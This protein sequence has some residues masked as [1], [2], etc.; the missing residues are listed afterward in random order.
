[1]DDTIRSTEPD[2]SFFAWLADDHE[3]L[4]LGLANEQAGAS[5]AEI[6]SAFQTRI[7]LDAPVS[8]EIAVLIS[9]EESDDGLIYK[10]EVPQPLLEDLK[11]VRLPNGT[12]RLTVSAKGYATEYRRIRV[13]DPADVPIDFHLER[14]PLLQGS[15]VDWEG[16]PL[17]GVLIE[18]AGGEELARSD[19]AGH[20]AF[21]VTGEIP[22]AIEFRLPGYGLRR[23]ELQQPEDFAV[24]VIRMYPAATMLVHFDPSNLFED[25]IA[26]LSVTLYRLTDDRLRR[27]AHSSIDAG[28]PVEFINLDPGDYRVHLQGDG[29]LQQLVH[30]ASVTSS[31]VEEVTLQPSA[32]T[33]DGRLRRDESPV[34]DAGVILKGLRPWQA[35]LTSDDEGRFGGEIWQSG[36]FAILVSGKH[37]DTPFGTMKTFTGDPVRLDIEIPSSS[38]YGSVVDASSGRP[39]RDAKIHIESVGDNVRFA[40]ST[41]TDAKGDYRFTAVRNGK[42]SLRVTAPDYLTAELFFEL[43]RDQEGYRADVRLE[44]GIEQ[45]VQILDVS[46]HPAAHATIM[47]GVSAGGLKPGKIITADSAGRATIRSREAIPAT[48]YVFS[49]DGSFLVWPFM[50]S[51]ET[52]GQVLVLPAASGSV[53]IRAVDEESTPVAR[54]SFLVRH[55]GHLLLP[56]VLQVMRAVQ[57]RRFETDSDG[58]LTFRNLPA[59]VYEFWPY[60]GNDS[61]TLLM[62]TPVPG[63]PS[64]TVGVS[65]ASAHHVLVRLNR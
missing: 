65:N 13:A 44:R 37:L 63:M 26:A 59:G 17:A 33:L 23:L 56:G 42:H 4:I 20:F 27:V 64:L 5:P 18:G 39:V 24:G 45:H 57:N 11:E 58:V 12:Y 55:N 35:A 48:A 14:L 10:V 15:I 25:Q 41:I 7:E 9:L 50:S 60:A 28:S 31:E 51:A 29:E 61:L 8:P 36:D 30:E 34:A 6:H 46:G 47:T 21:N 2:D 1:M 22:R 19:R 3:T 38:V 53:T 49:A 43:T 62:A 16:R 40:T 52:E 54:I 32:I